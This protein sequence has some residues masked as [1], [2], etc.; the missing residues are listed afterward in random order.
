METCF[1]AELHYVQLQLICQTRTIKCLPIMCVCCAGPCLHTGAVQTDTYCSRCCASC[2]QPSPPVKSSSL[3]LY[4]YCR[5]LQWL[6][7]TEPWV[8]RQPAILIINHLFNDTDIYWYFRRNVIN[9]AGGG[10]GWGL[11][12]HEPLPQPQA[13][14]AEGWLQGKQWW[15]VIF[16][17]HI[18]LLE[19]NIG[20]DRANCAEPCGWKCGCERQLRLPVE[21][22]FL[23]PRSGGRQ[24]DWLVQ[25]PADHGLH[26][27]YILAIFDNVSASY[28]RMTINK[29][30]CKFCEFNYLAYAAN[31]LA[32]WSLIRWNTYLDIETDAILAQLA[33]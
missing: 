13:Q 23:L 15:W 5:R 21:W 25:T 22:R 32:V 26:I 11:L 9:W 7:L 1:F 6:R 29:L 3:S 18:S 14:A 33:T 31:N 19:R 12:R 30:I 10:R 20:L 17:S 27:P 4:C 16:T 24:I 28:L 2:P 8:R